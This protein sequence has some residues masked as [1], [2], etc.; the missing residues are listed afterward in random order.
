MSGFGEKRGTK[1]KRDEYEYEQAFLTNP[2]NKELLRLIKSSKQE[3]GNP[4]RFDDFRAIHFTTKDDAKYI[5]S[6][7]KP[8]YV[9]EEEQDTYEY[10]LTSSLLSRAT[11]SLIDR[12]PNTILSVAINNRGNIAAGCENGIVYYIEKNGNI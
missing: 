5:E 6:Y 9:P 8:E 3:P 10:I 2:D 1:S 12:G 11:L 4:R 7:K